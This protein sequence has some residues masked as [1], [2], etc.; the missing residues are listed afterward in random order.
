MPG[1]ISHLNQLTMV[2]AQVQSDFLYTN[3]HAHT[4]SEI[5]YRN[6]DDFVYG[7]EI[8]IP[9]VGDGVITTWDPDNGRIETQPLE[10]GEVLFR[11]TDYPASGWSIRNHTNNFMAPE[12]RRKLLMHQANEWVRL[13][14]ERTETRLFEVA[15][16]SQVANDPN[17]INNKAHRIVATGGVATGRKVTIADLKRMK[18]AFNKAY[19][20]NALVLFLDSEGI[21]HLKDEYTGTIS[22]DANPQIQKLLNDGSFTGN[23]TYE[24]NF[25]GWNVFHSEFLPNATDT[26]DGTTAITQGVAGKEV[27]AGVFL[28]LESD[29]HKALIYQEREAPM[30]EGEYIP[31]QRKWEYTA[32]ASQGFGVAR[33]DTIGTIIYHS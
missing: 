22:N 20:Y 9:T 1:T 28:C 13:Y 14:K 31:N 7:N 8:R 26:T 16:A 4:V 29:N 27:K 15:Y 12:M 11:L 17:L 33:T 3:L 6:V 19:C 25:Y 18:V 24:G 23:H 2:E 21:E 32:N 10:T 30:V 5:L